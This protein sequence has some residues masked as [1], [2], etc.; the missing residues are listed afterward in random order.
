MIYFGGQFRTQ[1]DW[2]YD[3]QTVMLHEMGHFLGLLHENT[4]IQESVMY[5]TISQQTYN[6]TPLD[7]DIQNIRQKYLN[8]SSSA[9]YFEG[10]EANDS[11][12]NEEEVRIIHMLMA[13]GSERT[14]VY[15]NGKVKTTFHK[16]NH[17]HQH[18]HKH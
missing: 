1:Q 13:D 6:R 16:C 11:D 15:A 8:N 5:P 10:L 3:F 4:S 14:R 17:K 2:G 9:V 12:E 18:N 7:D